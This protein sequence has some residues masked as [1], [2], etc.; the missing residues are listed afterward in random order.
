M[1]TIFKNSLFIILSLLIF[2]SC[3]EQEGMSRTDLNL[4]R[5]E[6][7]RTTLTNDFNQVAY[8]LHE[9]N[10]TFFDKKEVIKVAETYYGKKSSP[11]NSFLDTFNKPSVTNGRLN[12]NLNDFQRKN[13]EEI[14]SSLSNYSSLSEF[15]ASLDDKFNNFMGQSIND[16]DKDFILSYI[17]AYKVSLDFVVNNQELFVSD[18]AI[19]GR[20]W[21]GDW[22]KCAAGVVGGAIIGGIGGA[23][24]CSLGMRGQIR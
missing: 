19:N 16:V 3:N 23:V 2:S 24:R 5:Y 15:Q 11:L 1:K 17:T 20:G 4:E 6:L 7:L 13:V 8:L 14:T 10:A 21:W 12:D 22:G 9:N 18:T